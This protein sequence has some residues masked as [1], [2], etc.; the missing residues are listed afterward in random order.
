MSTSKPTPST[1]VKAPNG[2]AGGPSKSGSGTPGAVTLARV[3]LLGS[4]GLSIYLAM[5]S[6][7]SGGVAGCGPE[8]GCGEVL[9]SRW[10]YWLGIPVS[11]PA[12]LMYLGMLGLTF[13]VAREAGD[14]AAKGARLALQAGS[15]VM[16][17]AAIWFVCLQAFSVGKFCPFC[18]TTHGLATVAAV[19]LMRWVAPMAG[20]DLTSALAAGAVAMGV[21]VMGQYAV[22]PKGYQVA[23]MNT[24]TASGQ[25]KVEGAKVEGGKQAAAAVVVPKEVPPTLT[26]HSNRFSFD[27]TEYPVVGNPKAPHVIVSLFD[28]TCKY[29]R[30]THMPIMEVQRAFSN[31]MAVLSL[32]MPLDSQCNRYV[33]RTSSAHTNACSFAALGLAVWRADRAKFHKF[34]DWLMATLPRTTLD[35]ARLEAAALV[36]S[37]KLEKSLADPWV[38]KTIQ[39]AI[40]LYGANTDLVRSGNMPQTI[41]GTN[42]VTGT[43]HNSRQLFELVGRGFGLKLQ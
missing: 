17:A 5:A 28:Y 30:A 33:K 37:E 27:L 38:Q 32:P 43:I 13:K 11:I 21:V 23:A 31:Q 39:L 36:G 25:A 18:C 26:L 29:C 34:D 4:I 9:K 10:A 7:T 6:L 42:I 16:I 24:G 1:P 40:D 19:L 12:G 3:L 22:E 15:L 20:A 14:V 2:G 8:G 41:V 35:Q